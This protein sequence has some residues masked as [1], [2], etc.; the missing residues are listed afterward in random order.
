M[1]CKLIETWGSDER[2]IEAARMSTDGAFRGWPQDEKLLRYLA[3]HGHVSP[4]EQAGASFE[5]RAPIFVARQVFRHKSFSF[6]EHSGRY[7]PMPLDFYEPIWR[8]QADKNKQGSGALIRD[9]AIA[10]EYWQAAVDACETVYRNLLSLGISREH[11]RTVLP[12]CTYTRFRMSGNLRSW[13]H[14]FQARVHPD[15]QEDTRLLAYDMQELLRP[16]FPRSLSM[17]G[18]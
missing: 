3:E 13:V 2:I 8:P 6:N 16:H 15:A 12:L 18:L 9:P 14:F 5:I 11:A 17:H 7:S 10:S 1:E 4:F